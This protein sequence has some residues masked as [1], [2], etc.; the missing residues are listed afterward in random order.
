MALTSQATEELGNKVLLSTKV[1][2]VR[3]KNGKGG[4]QGS[5]HGSL[6]C[7]IKEL[8]LYPKH[9]REPFTSFR[10]EKFVN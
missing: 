3:I 8:S 1:E 7:H 2:V 6:G 5:C 4:G 9:N 10:Q